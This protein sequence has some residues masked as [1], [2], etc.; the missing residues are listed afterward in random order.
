MLHSPLSVPFTWDVQPGAVAVPR[1]HAMGSLGLM[2]LSVLCMAWLLAMLQDVW[3]GVR[4]PG[5]LVCCLVGA[6]LSGR[7][8]RRAWSRWHAV[9]PMQKLSW[10]GVVTPGHPEGGWRLGGPLG[11]PAELRCRLDVQ[12]GLLCQVRVAG[13]G[14]SAGATHWFWITARLC[15]DLHL[16]R[17]L[18]TLPVASTTA[19]VTLEKGASDACA[20]KVASWSPRRHATGIALR[21]SSNAF[22]PTRPM[23]VTRGAYQ[24][25]RCE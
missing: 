19:S 24:E 13:E 8:I 1:V 22:K 6:W 11:D 4:S 5:W 20:P 14:A 9:Q 3:L 12:G 23:S 16:F 10:C 18:V 2:A 25:H 21:A 7:Q 17:T 15:P